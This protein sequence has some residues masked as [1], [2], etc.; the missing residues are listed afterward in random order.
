MYNSPTIFI[1]KICAWNSCSQDGEFVIVGYK[2]SRCI[3]IFP[4]QNTC[5]RR[6]ADNKPSSL[7]PKTSTT[8]TGPELAWYADFA[9]SGICKNN[10]VS[11][12]TDQTEV[13]R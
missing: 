4:S 9:S 7:A 6:T 12:K 3:C 1:S 5:C 8:T 10:S 2:I 13:D 11:T